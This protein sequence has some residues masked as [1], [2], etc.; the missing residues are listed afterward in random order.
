MHRF[1]LPPEQCRG[2]AFFL[3][4]SEAH[5]AL[6]VLRL[7]KGEKV[8]VLDGAGRDCFCVV[9]NYDRDKVRLALEATRLVEPSPARITLLQAIPKGKIIE[10]IIQKATEL[11]VARIV[12]LLTARV[13]TRLD[14]REGVRK[15]SKWQTIAIEAIKQC[16]N[17]WLPRVDAPVSPAEYLARMEQFDLPLI[18]SL[19]SD[20]AHPRKHFNAYRAKHQHDPR[21]IS[22]W[23]GP[24]GDFTPEEAGMIR[25]ADALPITLGPLV[26]RTETAAIYC[27][28][29]LNYELRA[30]QRC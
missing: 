28:S 30:N 4:G 26:L 7:R 14:D 1:Y 10:S 27:L 6:H 13:T 20:P 9:E 12:P 22:I 29:V 19:Q 23:I 2:D 3:S 16:G 17:A 25:A 8:A 5:H 11:G 21:S 18:A 24:E 15:A